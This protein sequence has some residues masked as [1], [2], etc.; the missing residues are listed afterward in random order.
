MLN[1]ATYD[2]QD[3]LLSYAGSIYDYTANGELKTKTT[4]ALITSYDYDVFGNLKHV[5]LPDGTAIDY[6]I[7]GQNRRIGRKVGGTLV[8]SFL[9]QGDLKP[10]AEL[11]GTNTVVSRF[12][13]GADVNVPDYMVK[14]G[15][16]Y[17]II[18]DHLGRPAPR[19]Q[20][21]GWRHCPAHGLRRIRASDHRY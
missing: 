6:V 2:D 18:T 8:Q 3:R 13:Y 19:R 5:T 1:T 16:T 7:D 20:Y 11:D 15:V 4:G 12:V 9:Y 17:R 21:H 10:I 14:G